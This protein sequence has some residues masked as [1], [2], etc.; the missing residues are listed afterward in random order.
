MKVA[1]RRAGARRQTVAHNSLVHCHRNSSTRSV[2]ETFDK[3]IL[4]D[5]PKPSLAIV[6]SRE[7]D[8]ALF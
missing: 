2:A 7:E 4:N 3:L 1:R 6:V 8:A 5:L